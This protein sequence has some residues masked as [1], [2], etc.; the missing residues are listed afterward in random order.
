MTKVRVHNFTMSLDGFVAGPLQDIDH[1]LGVRGEQLHEWAFATRTF[2][3]MHEMQGGEVSIDDEIAAAAR[4]NVGA[5]IIGRNMFGPIRGDWPDEPWTGWW[6]EDPPYHHPVFVLTHHAR[7][8]L[9]MQGGTIFHFV[10]DGIESA[11]DRARDAAGSSDVMIGGGAS[12]VRQFLAAGLIDEMHVAV[13]PV[14]LGDG[15][16]LFG[17]LP[18]IAEQYRF[19]PVIGS[20]A[21]AHFQLRRN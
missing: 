3:D 2:R 14:L 12:T 6:G 16:R 10:T 1:P 7:P 17:G 9:E 8:S 15:E 5:H 13:V 4:Q 18:D 11:L 21:A 20:D 19:E